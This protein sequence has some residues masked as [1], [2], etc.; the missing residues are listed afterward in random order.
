MVAPFY[1]GTGIEFTDAERERVLADMG[2]LVQVTEA[3]R[4]IRSENGIHPG[5]RIETQLWT[6]ASDKHAALAQMDD[7]L[8]ELARIETLSFVSDPEAPPGSAAHLVDGVS[9]FVPLAGL[10]DFASEIG[11]LENRL[12]QLEADLGRTEKKLGNEQFMTRAPQEIREK[13][14]QKRDEFQEQLSQVR[15]T[16]ARLQAAQ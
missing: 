5:K 3:V 7:Y 14:M 2:L 6:E 1:Q 16:L 13:E 10:I 4:T 12:T 15:E 11:R 9:V 8:K